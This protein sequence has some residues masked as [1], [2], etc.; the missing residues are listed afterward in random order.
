MV[1]HLA[2]GHFHIGSEPPCMSLFFSSLSFHRTPVSPKG[3][4]HF[5]MVA[6]G[7]HVSGDSSGTLEL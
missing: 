5:Q 7:P 2:V 4:S 1:S 3:C 6:L